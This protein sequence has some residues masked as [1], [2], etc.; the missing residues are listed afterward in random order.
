MSAQLLWAD[1]VSLICTKTTGILCTQN[2]RDGSLNSSASSPN[3]P[4]TESRTRG[5]IPMRLKHFLRPLL[6]TILILPIA[7]LLYQ[8][9]ATGIDQRNAPRPG[10]L[11]DVGGYRLY[12]D[13]TGENTDHRPTVVF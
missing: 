9:I 10:G 11:V 5:F 6:A 4:S 3:P 8:A 1:S 13:C 12:L 2:S 7:G